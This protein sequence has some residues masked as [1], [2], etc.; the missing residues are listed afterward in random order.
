MYAYSGSCYCMRS[1]LLHVDFLRPAVLIAVVSWTHAD[2]PGY[3][4]KYSIT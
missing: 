1:H 3:V 2:L 4:H